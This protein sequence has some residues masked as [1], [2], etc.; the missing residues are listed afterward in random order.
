MIAIMTPENTDQVELQQS[1]ADIQ[2]EY[3]TQ[4]LNE[5]AVEITEIAKEKGFWEDGFYTIPLK[6]VLIHDEA[7]EALRVHREEYDGDEIPESGMTPRQEQD[8]GE[9]LADIIIRTLDLA[10]YYDLDIGFLITEK[11]AKN[12]ERPRKHG[13]RY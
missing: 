11:M 3:R 9:E 7:S 5:L 10:G 2:Q 4:L 1:R 8:F 13:K 6:L 12:K